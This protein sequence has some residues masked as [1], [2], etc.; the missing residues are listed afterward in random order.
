M[1]WSRQLG[2]ASGMTPHL[3]PGP[4]GIDISSSVA[5]GLYALVA[6]DVQRGFLCR[7]LL[8]WSLDALFRSDVILV[9]FWMTPGRQI[10]SF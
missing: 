6:E 7:G 8:P 10:V 5:Q 3:F 1:H 4:S 2:A 9:G